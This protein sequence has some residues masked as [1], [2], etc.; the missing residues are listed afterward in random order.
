M[1]SQALAATHPEPD[2]D[3]LLKTY[4]SLNPFPHLQVLLVHI[5][6][7]TLLP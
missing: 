3:R 7:E 2:H 4:K 6:D 1:S 5:L